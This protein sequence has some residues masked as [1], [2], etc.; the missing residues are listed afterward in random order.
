MKSFPQ[1]TELYTPLKLC[2]SRL[3]VMEAVFLIDPF[4]MYNV[5]C[6]YIFS[7]LIPN[8][9]FFEKFNIENRKRKKSLNVVLLKP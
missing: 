4:W 5:D 3:D 8:K 2:E 7:I 1:N 6:T 9:Y